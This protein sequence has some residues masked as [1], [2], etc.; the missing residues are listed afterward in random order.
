MSGA[1]CSVRAQ[2]RCLSEQLS[3]VKFNWWPE[4]PDWVSETSSTCIFIGHCGRRPSTLGFQRKN[5][6]GR[7]SSLAVV[8]ERINGP[9]QGAWIDLQEPLYD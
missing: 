1:F 7:V 5:K 9:R 8:T 6:K 4:G 2:A 3:S